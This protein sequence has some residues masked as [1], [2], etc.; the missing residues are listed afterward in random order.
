MSGEKRWMM[1]R[2]T[3][4]IP[5]EIIYEVPKEVADGTAPPGV[6]EMKIVDVIVPPCPDCGERPCCCFR[7]VP[8]E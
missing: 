7:E 2:M 8:W 1:D 4:P 6:Y 3:G 5:I